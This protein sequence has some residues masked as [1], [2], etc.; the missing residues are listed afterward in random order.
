MVVAILQRHDA[1][2]FH[3]RIANAARAHVLNEHGTHRPHT[4]TENCGV[5]V[6]NDKVGTLATNVPPMDSVLKLVLEV[7]RRDHG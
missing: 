2:F 1:V 4:A 5:C 6:I 3:M 7:L